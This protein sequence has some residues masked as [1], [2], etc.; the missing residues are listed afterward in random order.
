MS[1]C[2]WNDPSVNIWISSMA[3]SHPTPQPLKGTAKKELKS[4]RQCRWSLKW[5]A[6][7][8]AG[9]FSHNCPVSMVVVIPQSISLGSSSPSSSRK[10]EVSSALTI[11]N[12][13]FIIL[14]INDGLVF[15]WVSRRCQSRQTRKA[16]S[17]SSLRSSIHRAGH[18]L[19]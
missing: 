19:K 5:L 14:N 1:C 8:M 15:I 6:H 18:H 13:P 17:T 7:T 16:P 9:T 12:I 10:M 2:L 4:S 3:S 11:S